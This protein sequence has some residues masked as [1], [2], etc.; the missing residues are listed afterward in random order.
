MPMAALLIYLDT[1]DDYKRRGPDPLVYVRD[2]VVEPT[3]AKVIVE[4]GNSEALEKERMKYQAFKRALRN[5]PFPLKITV[6]MA[7]TA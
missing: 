4:W 3:G 5:K 2:Y 7:D 1:W 6:R